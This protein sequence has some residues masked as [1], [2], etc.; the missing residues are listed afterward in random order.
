MSEQESEYLKQ[1]TGSAGANM[2]FVVGF[3]LYRA[4]QNR[5]SKSKSKCAT[6]CGWC[7]LEIENDGSS[8]SDIEEGVTKDENIRSRVPQ[9][10][11]GHNRKL[12][13]RNQE[14]PRSPRF[15]IRKIRSP[16]EN[17]SLVDQ[18]RTQEGFREIAP[19][20]KAIP[21]RRRTESL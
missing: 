16:T 14:T 6:H 1:F 4:L 12:S 11:Q 15:D 13:P 3:L 7:D 2:I 5:C 10:Q 18:T 8:E 9:M 19:L 17:W 20:Q 21:E